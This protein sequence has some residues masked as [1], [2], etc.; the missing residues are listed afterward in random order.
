MCKMKLFY[1]NDGVYR[2]W[3]SCVLGNVDIYMLVVPVDGG[4]I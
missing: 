4:P 3:V 2:F 1:V